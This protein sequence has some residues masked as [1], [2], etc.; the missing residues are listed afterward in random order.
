MHIS[1]SRVRAPHDDIYFVVLQASPAIR[2]SQFDQSELGG[3]AQDSCRKSTTEIDVH[4][5]K[6]IIERHFIHWS[7][8]ACGSHNSCEY[9]MMYRVSCDQ[10]F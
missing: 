4:S 10:S 6:V 8:K 1:F 7:G 2:I 3:I 5:N 9:V